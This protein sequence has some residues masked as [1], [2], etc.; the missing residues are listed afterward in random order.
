MKLQFRRVEGRPLI[1]R[2][3]TM[4][5]VSVVVVVV[6][7]LDRIHS[8]PPRVSITVLETLPGDDVGVAG[9]INERGQVVGY[10]YSRHT[11]EHHPVLW[12]NGTVTQLAGLDAAYGINDR[13]QV[14][15][16]RGGIEFGHAALWNGRTVTDLDQPP[17]SFFSSADAMNL[18]GE[19]VGFGVIGSVDD[20]QFQAVV[21]QGSIM[22][23]LPALP[24]DT[25]SYAAAVNGRG[26]IVG[27]SVIGTVGE[28]RYTPVLWRKGRPIPL[29]SSP[30]AGEGA[31][32]TAINNRGQVAG[33]ASVAGSTHAVLWQNGTVR[34][35]GTL[36]GDELSFCNDINDRGQIV[37]TSGVQPNF[38]H[39]V[40][41]E[42]GVVIDLGALP[43]DNA[44]GAFG[45][46]NRGQVVGYSGDHAVVWQLPPPKRGGK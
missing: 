7:G 39:A 18:R 4:V 28:F 13:G 36:P 11:G 17:N 6:F 9:D 24:G 37:G 43:G 12:Q 42:A 23:E 5:A 44:S 35:L 21:W 8:A 45:I 15:G 27:G 29:A 19:I 34:D 31:S 32:A 20:Y 38:Y 22:T 14:V 25:G 26:D 3:L 1:T 33:N 30:A 16:I 40:L 10:S 46:N 2:T 41:W